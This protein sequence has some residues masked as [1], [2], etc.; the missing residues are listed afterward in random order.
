MENILVNIVMEQFLPKIRVSVV[1]VLFSEFLKIYW[2][3]RIKCN[4]S[5]L[6]YIE[7]TTC[8]CCLSGPRMI[9]FGF[10]EFP[11]QVVRCEKR[12]EGWHSTNKI[13]SK[14]HS[15]IICP[16]CSS[17][18]VHC[19]VMQNE[20]SNR[21][22]VTKDISRTSF[23]WFPYLSLLMHRTLNTHCVLEAKPYRYNI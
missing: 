23:N 21:T 18:R 12:N 3:V 14:N 11:I 17:G 16:A 13:L 10:I 5:T 20:N 1:W 22:H 2:H 15:D 9:C 4:S 19:G 8:N 6:Y 7:R